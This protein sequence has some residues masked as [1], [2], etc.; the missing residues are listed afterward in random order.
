MF[1]GSWKIDDYVPIPVTCHR[2]SSGAAYAPSA[3][4]Y[5]IYEDGGTTGIAED[6]DMTPASPHDGVVGFYLARPQLT[7]ASGFEKGKNYTVLIKATVDS[8]S[9]IATHTFQIEAEV[10]ANVVSGSV[11]LQATQ[12][13]V[14]IPTVTTVTNGVTLADDAITN[15]KF[16]ETSAFP[17]K[18]ADTGATQIARV[19]ADSD[20]LETLS[21]EIALVNDIVSN[22]AITGSPAYSAPSSYVLTSG[23]QSSGT[24]ANVDT[25]NGVYHEHTSTTDAAGLLDLYYE[26]TLQADEQAVGILFKGRINGSNDSALIQAYDWTVPAFV[27]LFT[28]TGTSGTVDTNQS[29]ALVSKYTGTGVNLGKVRIRIVNAVALTTATLRVDQLL[30]SKTITNRSIGYSDGAIWVDTVNGTAGTSSFVNGTADLPVLTW[31][32]ALTISAA[33][34][35]YRFHLVGNSAITLTSTAAG[36]EFYGG[37]ITLGNQDCSN[38][39]FN[40]STVTGVQGTSTSDAWLFNCIINAVSGFLGNAWNCK[41]RG[42]IALAAGSSHFFSCGSAGPAV[43]YAPTFDFAA[44]NSTIGM[45]LYSG[46]LTVDN[47]TASDI[48][49]FDSPAGQLIL[50]ASCTGGEVRLR[51]LVDFENSGTG[52]LVT[53]DGPI[54][55]ATT[56]Y[57]SSKV[58]TSLT[59]APTDMALESTLTTI[60]GASWSGETLHAIHDDLA[61]AVADIQDVKDVVDVIAVDTTTE[62]PL[63]ITNLPDAILD[64]VVV[65]SYT[66]RQILKITAAGIAGKATGG[67]TTT[68]TFRG[69]DD[70]SNVIVETVDANGN[71]SAVTL[72]V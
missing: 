23:A 53:Q 41:I 18:S 59:N 34:K 26:Y 9:A 57:V 6:V 69:I 64:E 38:T 40:Y 15:A 1:L 4:T 66:M 22:I 48:L 61:A 47:L 70:T 11:L 5:S 56:G 13:G 16:D 12:T 51:G 60:K 2:F 31:A 8:I 28:L 32:D 46:K 45:R 21:D 52:V 35:I 44:G 65:G 39:R 25:S 50:N 42:A 68:I 7:A 17:V 33:L 71:R 19:G 36:R 62:I 67:G 63:S 30:V 49:S 14:T 29:P 3:L 24:F 58:A 27:T 72:T 54:F 55:D 43:G 10:D 37:T 20:T